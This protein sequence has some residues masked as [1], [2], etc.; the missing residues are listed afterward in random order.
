MGT[1]LFI[2]NLSYNVTE[3]E[4]REAFGGEGI[5]LRSVRL[6][7]DR[8]SGRPR[9]FAF[10]ETMTDDGAKASI[11]KLSGRML[12]GR[13]IIVPLDAKEV[14][15]NPNGVIAVDG[16]PIGRLKMV[17]FD[18]QEDAM[19]EGLTLFTNAPDKA[20][21]RIFPTT[22]VEQGYLE[23]ANVNAVSETGYGAQVPGARE[24]R[25]DSYAPGAGFNSAYQSPGWK[26]A[27]ENMN[28]RGGFTGKPPQIDGEARLVVKSGDNDSHYGI[29]DR[30]FHQKFGY[31]KIR[32]VEGNK[33]TVDFDK[34]GEKRVI[35]SFV[36]PASAA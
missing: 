3:Q 36:I 16:Q 31:G 19:R 1:R 2:G 7:L 22:T 13:P 25:F 28:S 4:L 35:D 15:I 8:E 11:E 14:Q 32:G 18:T 34:A 24:A 20:A 29:G 5:E 23:S 17:R 27:Q 10:V 33:L 30:I 12:Q 9:G 21:K 6:A 26:R